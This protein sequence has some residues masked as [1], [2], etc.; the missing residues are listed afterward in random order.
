MQRYSA[1]ATLESHASRQPDADAIVSE[2]A[3]LSY[4]ELFERVTSLASWLLQ[5]GFVPGEVT[6]ISVQDRVGHVVCGMALLALHT[7]QVNL[8]SHE[9]AANK[10]ALV[11]KLAV[12]QIVAETAED[13][14][15]GCEVIVAPVR[16]VAAAPLVAP[17]LA[18]CDWRE[19]RPLD[20]VAIY[21]NT[22]G[23]TSV[24]KSFG[25]TL[26]RLTMI[27]DRLANTPSERRVLRTGSVEFDASRLHR[28]CALLAGNSCIMTGQVHL[29]DL[30]ALCER[31]EVTEIQMGTYKLASLMHAGAREARRL[32][33]FTRIM[34]GGSRVPGPLR[35]K[36]KASL[37]DNL[38]VSYA[39]SEVGPISLASPQEH[40]AFPEG[41]GV[42]LSGVVVEIL[43]ADG[44]P[45]TPG[46]V[47]QARVRKGG[48][49]GEYL[50]DKE[51]S[52]V[53]RDGWFYPRD[54]LSR[55]EGGPLIFHG[56]VD[57]TMI[58]NG[59]NVFPGAIEDILESH[60]DVREA[61]AYAI[62]SRIHGEIPVAAVVLA[63]GARDRGIAHLIEHCRRSLGFRSPRQIFIVDH[64]PRNPA[65]KPLRRELA[66]S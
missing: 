12:A 53:F 64:I 10:R 1:F 29:R 33:A 8:P 50:G 7:P 59:I 22:S 60:P 54:L 2:D 41:V 38:W 49:P 26:A 19:G 63:D 14:M 51:S 56:R 9:T 15:E 5:H 17:S 48:A 3:R 61:A 39:T 40:E 45:A 13:W 27:A 52:S 24:P 65:G 58:L 30:A 66:Q 47:G 32:P 42:P 55:A 43:D 36:I 57:D 18:P 4:A 34:M 16:E 28:I 44:N 37:T 23:S 11:R 6:G 21:Q 35:H 20:A 62:P 46:D 31:A 25:L